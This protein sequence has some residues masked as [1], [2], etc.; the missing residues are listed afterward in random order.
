LPRDD[1]WRAFFGFVEKLRAAIGNSLKLDDAAD[2]DSP[3]YRNQR[4][5]LDRQ[6]G[7]RLEENRI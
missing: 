2:L 3:I 4:I 5:G 1:G 7:S 6:L